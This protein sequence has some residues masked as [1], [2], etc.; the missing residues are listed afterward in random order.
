M[1][2][3]PPAPHRPGPDMAGSADGD[4]GKDG[5]AFADP[6]PSAIRRSFHHRHTGSGGHQRRGCALASYRTGARFAHRAH[7]SQSSTPPPLPAGRQFC[8][9]ESFILAPDDRPARHV[10]RG[11]E[12]EQGRTVAQG[13]TAPSSQAVGR[14]PRHQ[15]SSSNSSARPPRA[16][17][18][19]WRRQNW[20]SFFGLALDSCSRPQPL[21]S[22]NRARARTP[23]IK[24]PTVTPISCAV[25]AS[26][27]RALI[28]T[29][30]ARRRLRQGTVVLDLVS[31][32]VGLKRRTPPETLSTQ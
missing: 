7:V 30:R 6:D 3:R 24:Q 26:A 21:P 1:P 11:G 13:A 5:D 2:T 25:G 19:R 8:R 23:T 22:A 17:G 20:A 14:L 15:D 32:D 4:D 27:P 31:R 12:G 10:R 29:R 18:G 9:H 28:G 16:L